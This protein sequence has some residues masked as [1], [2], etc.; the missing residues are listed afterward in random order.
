[1]KYFDE[2]FW[3]KFWWDILM[4]HFDEKFWWD[5]FMRHFY[6]TFLWNILMRHFNDTFLWDILMAWNT[7]KFVLNMSRLVIKLLNCT[8]DYLG[9]VMYIKYFCILFHHFSFFFFWLNFFR[10]KCLLNTFSSCCMLL[11]AI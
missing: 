4:R 2:K 7:W 1:M 5:I 8:T 10:F 3:W 11:H 6:G 9:L